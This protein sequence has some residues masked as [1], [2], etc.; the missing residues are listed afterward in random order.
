[1]TTHTYQGWAIVEI[2]GHRVRAGR[3][4]MDE[5]PI[6]RIDIPLKDAEAASEV[7]EY[8]GRAAV[9][10]MRPCTEEMARQVASDYGDPRP[11]RPLDYRP[12]NEPQLEYKNDDQDELDF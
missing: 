7:T 5:S 6:I 12:K 2:M 3:V 9:F 10:S 4:T 8:Y 11:V 1:M